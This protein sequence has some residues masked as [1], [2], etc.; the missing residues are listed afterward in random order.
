VNY[1][2]G[3]APNP[4]HGTCTLAT[5]K[6]F[7]R[8]RS[9]VGDYVIGT[10]SRS[11]KKPGQGG[12][13]VFIMRVTELSDFNNYWEDLRFQMKKPDLRG[14][15]FQ[16]YGDNIYW[17]DPRSKQWYQA[18]S[19]HS[20]ADGSL[21]AQDLKTDTGHTEKVLLSTDFTYWGRNGPELPAALADFAEK[22][23]REK[24]RYTQE[25]VDHFIKW[26]APLIGIGRVGEPYDWDMR[27]RSR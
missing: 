10:G 5:C 16:Q 3:F 8:K 2:L 17:R 7:I 11:A 22:G 25:Q 21:S 1:D 23:V 19:R 13:A 20:L 14:S 27:K 26:A 9:R 4:F 12:R 24:Y 15:L 6:P 18:N